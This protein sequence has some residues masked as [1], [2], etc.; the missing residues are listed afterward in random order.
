MKKLALYTVILSAGLLAVAACGKQQATNEVEWRSG[1]VAL[2]NDLAFTPDGGTQTITLNE[3]VT[4]AECSSA[5]ISTTIKGKVVE[6]TAEPWSQ[7]RSR[8]AKLT[9]KSAVGDLVVPVSQIGVI[10]IGL[11][12]QDI[13]SP[14]EGKVV[15]VEATL[16]TT[17][18][19]SADKDWIHTEY[20]AADNLVTI[21]VDD[22]TEKATREGTIT[23]TVAG[24]SKTAAVRQEPH[25]LKESAWSITAG[26]SYYNEP[27]FFLP[28][29]FSAGSADYYTL[30]AVSA[31]DVAGDL[32]SWIFSTLAPADRESALAKV[33]SDGGS[34]K[35]YLRKGALT[36]HN[37]NVPGIGDTYIIAI[38]F[39]ENTYI[40]GQYQYLRVNIPDTRPGYFDNE[41][42]NMNW[43]TF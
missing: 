11:D 17:L 4:K 40:T 10:I 2:R 12:I 5:W 26:E 1:L 42:E 31:D 29:S 43:G 7:S 27:D 8:Y 37:L 16:N 14:A 23:Y 41:G 3:T 30:H 9:L 32:E 20:S 35:D 33:A 13:L 18:D 21:T 22:N 28:V 39:G 34:F 25:L 36:G 6:V 19:I 38:G 24:T 15:T